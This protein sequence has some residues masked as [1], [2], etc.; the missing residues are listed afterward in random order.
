MFLIFLTVTAEI[1]QTKT[2]LTTER[3]TNMAKTVEIVLQSI[4]AVTNVLTI[5]QT[6]LV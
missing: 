4:H 1:V 5:L 3:L 2:T 6:T